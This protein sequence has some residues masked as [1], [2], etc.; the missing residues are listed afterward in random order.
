MSFHG[1]NVVSGNR[2]L[3]VCDD[4]SERLAVEIGGE[5]DD[6]LHVVAVDFSWRRAVIDGRHVGDQRA[7]GPPVI[8]RHHRQVRDVLE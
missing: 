2:L 7:T 8:V 6:P 4:L 5:T 1:T 3:N